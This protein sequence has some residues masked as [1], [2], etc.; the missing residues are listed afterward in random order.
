MRDIE[1][2]RQEVD[3]RIE[4]FLYAFVSVGCAA[5]NGDDLV[6]AGGFS[7]SRLYFILGNLLALEIFLE[8][9]IVCVCERFKHANPVF[10]G[11]LGHIGR[12]IDLRN[13]CAHIIII[14]ISLHFNEID[15]SGKAS[16]AAD[17]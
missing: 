15:Y 8:Q 7:D 14:D 6:C 11:F 13:F 2:R 5:Y 1:R 12:Y 4:Q 16:F 9:H 17:R 3:N 10:I